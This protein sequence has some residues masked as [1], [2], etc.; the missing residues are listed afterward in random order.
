MNKNKAITTIFI[1]VILVLALVQFTNAQTSDEMLIVF[2][3]D[4]AGISIQVNATREINPGENMTI[5]LWINCTADGVDVNYLILSVYGFRYGQEKILL[6]STSLIESVPLA[7]NNISQYNCIVN[8][9][10]DVWDAT[11]SELHLKYSIR[12]SP[13]EYNPSFSSTIVRNVYLE[14]LEKMFRSLNLT[15]WQ[16]NQ[17]FWES[18]N[19]NL[20]AENL[21]QLNKTYWEYQQNYTSLQGTLNELNNTRQAAVALA[22]TTVFFVA[23][24]VYLVM[25][26]PKQ[27][28]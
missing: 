10:N 7:F 16:L 26:K 11:Y 20:S 18:F 9:S 22:I 23:T 8:A 28:W 4:Y 3:K 15:Y 27:Y 19:M 14:E 13:F 6:N 2:S 5:S 17:S 12:D 25:R 24:T 1:T 21:A